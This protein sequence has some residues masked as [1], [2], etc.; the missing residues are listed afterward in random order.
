MLNLAGTSYDFGNVLFA[1]LQECEHQRRALLPNQA[2]ARLQEIA[3]A[4]LAE[5]HE[6]YTELG[7][8]SWSSWILGGLTVIA[9]AA[10]L[11]IANAAHG[12]M[13]GQ[14]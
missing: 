2:A 8:A 1:V 9:G 14:V 13:A 6:S 4:K 10:A 3:R 12:R 11:P 5:I 7:G